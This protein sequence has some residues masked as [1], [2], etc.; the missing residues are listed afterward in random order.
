MKFVH[1]C[2][3]HEPA[4]VCPSPGLANMSTNPRNK[5]KNLIEFGNFWIFI[6]LQCMDVL[7]GAN[8]QCL[9]SFYAS[10]ATVNLS[11]LKNTTLLS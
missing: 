6:G 2:V 7:N 3:I 1:S 9:D 11:T 5:G 8:Y 10:Y 4:V